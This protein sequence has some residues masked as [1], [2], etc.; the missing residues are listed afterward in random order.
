MPIV[1]VTFVQA[2]YILATFVHILNIS[3]ITDPIS[4]KLFRQIFLGGLKF[5][6]PHSFNQTSLDPN[7]FWTLVEVDLSW[8]DLSWQDLSWVDLSWLDLSRLDLSWLEPILTYQINIWTSH[9]YPPDTLKTPS[10]HLPDTLQTLPKQPQ[11]TLQTLTRPLLN[12][13][14]APSMQ[15]QDS[16]LRSEM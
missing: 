9:R 8:L 12:N 2:A 1:I 13:I 7:I 5:C 11:D 6:R 15:P 10:S 4:T 14:Q 3:D 16:H